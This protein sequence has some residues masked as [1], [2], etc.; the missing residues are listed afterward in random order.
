MF[1][2][3]PWSGLNP[4]ASPVPCKFYTVHPKKYACGLFTICYILLRFV[5]RCSSPIF[6]KIYF[7][8][9]GQYFPRS[10]HRVHTLLCFVAVWFWLLSPVYSGLFHWH[11]G[12]HIIAPVP[13]KQPW[14]IWV[15]DCMNPLG[16]CIVMT[17]ISSRVPDPK[18]VAVT[19]LNGWVNSPGNGSLIRTK[20]YGVSSSMQVLYSTS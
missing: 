6:F 3:A 13:V 4:M 12:N 11:L 2:W 15:I 17:S 19:W 16:T 5:T 18:L 1:L 8:I 14:R 7:M 20:S 10:I 9:H